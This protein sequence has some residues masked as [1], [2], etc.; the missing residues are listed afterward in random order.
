M[1][2]TPTPRD[3]TAVDALDPLVTKTALEMAEGLRAGEFTSEQLVQAH[4]DRIE[5][6]DGVLHAFLQVDAEGALATAREVDAARAASFSCVTVVVLTITAPFP[7]V[8]AAAC[9][10]DVLWMS[11]F[12]VIV[13]RRPGL[14]A[15]SP[16][17]VHAGARPRPGPGARCGPA[18]P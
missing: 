5:Q 3:T 1:T 12:A 16:P 13:G 8:V 15:P 11:A 17:R 2:T 7:A 9:G 6:V 14:G 10:Q 18:G 4:L